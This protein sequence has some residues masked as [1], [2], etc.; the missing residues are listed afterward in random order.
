MRAGLDGELVGEMG[1]S[2]RRA[3]WNAAG[4]MATDYF[5]GVFGRQAM[6]GTNRAN[7]FFRKDV[8]G[9][10]IFYHE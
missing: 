8:T 9:F 4:R 6:A 7:I 3:A 2:Q 1:P 5:G 10:D